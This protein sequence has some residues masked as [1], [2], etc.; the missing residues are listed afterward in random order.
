MKIFKILVLL[1]VTCHGFAQKFSASAKV[2][3][4]KT[5]GLHTIVL[6]PDF[7]SHADAN[8]DGIRILNSKGK[9]VPYFLDDAD[10]SIS[11]YGFKPYT[12]VSKN[13]VPNIASNVVI[14][15]IP[16]TKWNEVTLA[17]ANTDAHK[18]YSISGSHD[19]K[20]WFGLVNNQL[21]TDLYSH[22]DTLVYKTLAM[23]VNAYRYIKVSF[24][25]KK[26]LPIN[27]VAAGKVTDTLTGPVMQE[28]ANAHIKIT[29]LYNEKKTRITAMFNNPVTINQIV[30]HIT[31]PAFYQRSTKIQVSRLQKRRKRT[32]SYLDEVYRFDLNS[33]SKNIAGDLSLTENNL[34][35]DIDNKDNEP[36]SIASIRL[37]QAPVNIIAYFT[38][39]EH[40]TVMAGDPQLTAPDYDIK[41]FKEQMPASL[42]KAI[43]APTVLLAKPQ[44]INGGKSPWIM[45][46]CI[47]VGA[48]ILLYFC[49]SLVKDMKSKEPTA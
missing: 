37:Y 19:N 12:L 43:L 33:A 49:Y 20:E 38:A 4:I 26:T 44:G 29:Q 11:K 41:N 1:L 6:P 39:G 13:K 16:N 10:K 9:E 14:E 8:R 31:A 22:E 24:N 18:S 40:Y 30:F 27:V 21:L 32:Y 25:D 7:R 28:A 36:L 17:I 5:T 2:S 34:V 35:I 23:P 15:N 45:W 46:V 48:V 3:D 47:A 42:P